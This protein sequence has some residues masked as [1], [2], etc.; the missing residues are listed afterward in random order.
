MS[1]DQTATAKWQP[2]AAGDTF[3][4]RSPGPVTLAGRY[5]LLEPLDANH[6]EGLFNA[7]NSDD[8]D[9]L[10][11]F[12]ADPVCTSTAEVSALI[13]QKRITENAAYFASI[14]HFSGDTLGYAALMRADQRHRTIELGNLLFTSGLRRKRAG[15][16]VVY[17]LL[18]HAFE[19]LGYRR[20]EWK[21]NSINMPSRNAALRYG[22]SF[23]GVFRQHMV[24]KS[25]SRDTAWFS[26][27][28]HEWPYRREALETWLE[29][30]NFDA[31]GTQFTALSELNGVGGS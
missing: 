25:A 29:P 30:D 26:M 20:L 17:L 12:T 31:Y 18:R 7:L 15:T 1:Q 2:I 11:R 21:C 28:D 16:E 14:D 4:P 3:T 10:Q 8:Q 19:D 23:E 13:E 5:V 9:A 24:V 22:F 6:A 27:L